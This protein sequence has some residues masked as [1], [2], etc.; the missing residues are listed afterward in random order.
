[1]PHQR[2]VFVGDLFYG[3]NMAFGNNQVMYGGRRQ[4]VLKD[5]NFVGFLQD[6]GRKL[7]IDDFT[8]YAAFVGHTYDFFRRVVDSKSRAFTFSTSLC[9][10]M[11]SCTPSVMSRRITDP[12][13]A[14]FWPRITANF[15]P[16]F[17]AI[18]SCERKLSRESDSATSMP[19]RRNSSISVKLRFLA[20]GPIWIIKTF[21]Y[22]VSF[23]AMPR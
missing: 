8:K 11:V 16:T 1:M 17:A 22:G 5:N 21:G 12:S 13:I 4:N 9:C 23:G 14:S 6:L 18:L 3:R 10:I 2:L 7:F 15:A 19:S 20:A